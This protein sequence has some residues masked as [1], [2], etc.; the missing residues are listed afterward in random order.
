MLSRPKGATIPEGLTP[1]PSNKLERDWTSLRP[2]HKPFPRFGGAVSFMSFPIRCPYCVQGDN[3]RLME[4]RPGG[5]WFVCEKCGHTE[6]QD[7]PDFRC[8]CRKCEELSRH[9]EK[10]GT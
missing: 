4:S 2:S 8:C 9:T 5:R 6:M 3:F 10:Y 1:S 7:N